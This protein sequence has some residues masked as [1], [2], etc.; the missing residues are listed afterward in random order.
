MKW[1]RSRSDNSSDRPGRL[2]PPALLDR[3]Y[4]RVLGFA[5]QVLGDAELAAQ[6][7]ETIFVRRDPPQNEVAVWTAAIATMRSYV[8]R[9]F[10]VRPLVPQTQSWQTDLL[11]R[12]AQLE[13]L[14]RALLLLRYHEDLEL[15]DLAQVLGI[16]EDELRKQ[17]ALARGKLL[18][19]PNV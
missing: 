7:A 2:P 11:R 9:G 3:L 4:P 16:S 5:Y 17:V 15:E 1:P 19:L 13:P 18:D 8:A 10:V 12:L 6:S 14:E